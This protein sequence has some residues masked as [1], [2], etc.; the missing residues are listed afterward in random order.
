MVYVKI[1]EAP[2]AAADL[3]PLVRTDADGALVTFEGVVRD[4]NDGKG[5]AHLE[6]EAYAEM[7]EREMARIGAETLT[8]FGLHQIAIVHRVGRLAIGEVAV[9]IAVAS[10]HRREA[11]A[12]C[13][14]A[15]DAVKE[16]VPIWKKEQYTDG[17]D[18]LGAQA[19][20]RGQPASD[21]FNTEGS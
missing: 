18:W 1:T 7:A 14:H 8:R 11:F 21:L 16:R 9:A 12:A 2:I 17:A 13:A 5:V 15:I 4:H 10:P 20:H 19:E 3:L 6:Y